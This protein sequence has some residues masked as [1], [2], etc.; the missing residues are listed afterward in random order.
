MA[1]QGELTTDFEFHVT[2][3]YVHPRCSASRVGVRVQV[4]MLQNIDRHYAEAIQLLQTC[5][6]PD[7]VSALCAQR[8]SWYIIEMAQDH[9]RSNQSWL[10][11][12]P[13]IPKTGKTTSMMNPPPGT[14]TERVSL[15]SDKQNFEIL[16]LKKEVSSSRLIAKL[17]TSGIAARWQEVAR[18][19]RSRVRSIEHT[20]SACYALRKCNS[21]AL[22]DFVTEAGQRSPEVVACLHDPDLSPPGSQFCR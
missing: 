6:D 3:S 16:R 22:K 2:S 20:R 4:R 7:K 12:K 8:F 9:R 13:N 18:S 17:Y 5:N 19:G 14:G 15:Q 10:T 11:H 1:W 21:Q